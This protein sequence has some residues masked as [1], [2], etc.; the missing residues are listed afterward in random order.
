MQTII[1][2]GGKSQR[3]KGVY[4]LPKPL[5]KIDGIPVLMRIIAHYYR[6]GNRDFIIC[7]G[8]DDT[9]FRKRFAAMNPQEKQ[10]FP[11]A[12]IQILET[13]K[14]TMTG[15]RVSR[16]R[17]FINDDFCLTYG[18]GL[19]DDDLAA[20]SKVFQNRKPLCLMLVIHPV[21]NFGIIEFDKE[22]KVSH[23]REKPCLKEWINGGFF[24][25][26]KKSLAYFTD[27]ASL[28]TDVLPRLAMDRELMVYPHTGFWKCMDTPKDYYELNSIYRERKAYEN[29]KEFVCR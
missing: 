3:M 26:R 27:T 18:D 4:R 20:Q 19:S 24:I 2:C 12:A 23:F 28:E 1:L 15:G 14:D 29:S 10:L 5:L 13:G 17:D 22:Q 21:S 7:T 9:V 6:Y 8:A 25:F 16:I 11:D